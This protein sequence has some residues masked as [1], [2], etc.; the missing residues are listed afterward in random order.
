MFKPVT[1]VFHVLI[2]STKYNSGRLPKT[3][4]LVAPFDRGKFSAV[5]QYC[6]E[7]LNVPFKVVISILPVGI[8]RSLA[9]AYLTYSRL[10]GYQL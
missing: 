5:S 3:D 7:K 4:K 10:F 8:T 1:F 2:I 6:L 9:V